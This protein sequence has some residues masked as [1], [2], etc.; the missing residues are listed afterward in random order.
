MPSK[1]A[2][3]PP[4]KPAAEV[5]AEALQKE[6]QET[7]AVGRFKDFGSGIPASEIAPLSFRICGQTFRCR[8]LISAKKVL[9]LI[10]AGE[11]GEAAAGEAINGFL[12]SALMPEDLGRW[13][14]LMDSEEYVVTA[15]IL[16]DVVVW[17]IEQYSERPTLQ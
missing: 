4:V 16:S 10:S 8:P 12:A 5:I 11:G 1:K 7:E 15:D 13:E 17:L 14:E 9:H 2:A 3:A 6:P